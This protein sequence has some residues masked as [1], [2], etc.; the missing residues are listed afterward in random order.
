MHMKYE[1]VHKL[2][3]I[4]QTGS[5]RIQFAIPSISLLYGKQFACNI[6]ISGTFVYHPVNAIQA[7]WW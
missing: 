1:H 3:A 4:W 6:Q 7:D 2:N 5:E